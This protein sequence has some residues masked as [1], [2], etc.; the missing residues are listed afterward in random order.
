M[1]NKCI[2]F[3]GKILPKATEVRFINNSTKN[4]EIKKILLIDEK[5]PDKPEIVMLKLQFKDESTGGKLLKELEKCL[6]A[7]E[8]K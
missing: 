7:T 1:S 3:T 6:G 5:K 2:V 4:I 8:A